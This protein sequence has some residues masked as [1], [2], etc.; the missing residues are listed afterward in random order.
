M[1]GLVTAMRPDD[2]QDS[3][4]GMM[5]RAVTPATVEQHEIQAPQEGF[6]LSESNARRRP[7]HL[8]EPAHQSSSLF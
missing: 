2:R 1:A 7:A 3:A 5:I 8:A 4:I 6:H